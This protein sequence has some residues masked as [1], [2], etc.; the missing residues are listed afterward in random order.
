MFLPCY[1][2]M[3]KSN[4]ENI[5]EIFFD[6]Q[7]LLYLDNDSLDK[8]LGYSL[9]I[10]FFIDQNLEKISQFS[11][12]ENIKN[13]TLKIE[14]INQKFNNKHRIIILYRT[15]NLEPKLNSINAK[16]IININ[17]LDIDVSKEYILRVSDNKSNKI[18]SF[19][20]KNIE[21]LKTPLFV[22]FINWICVKTNNEDLEQIDSTS[23]IYQIFTRENLRNERKNWNTKD[24]FTWVKYQEDRD[25]LFDWDEEKFSM[26]YNEGKKYYFEKNP[27][28]VE[29]I[30][31][32]LAKELGTNF[33]DTKFREKINILIENEEY[34]W[35][36]EYRFIKNDLKFE[37]RINNSLNISSNFPLLKKISEFEIEFLHPSFSDYYYAKSIFYDLKKGNLI[38][39]EN[40]EFYEKQLNEF[41]WKELDIEASISEKKTYQSNLLKNHTFETLTHFINL[42]EREFNITSIEYETIDYFLS[43]NISKTALFYLAKAYETYFYS[44]LNYNTK[45]PNEI[46]DKGLNPLFIDYSVFLYNKSLETPLLENEEEKD[47]RSFNNLGNIYKNAGLYEDAE[48]FYKKGIK[49]NSDFEALHFNLGILYFEL[50]NYEEAILSFNESVRIIP[51]GIKNNWALSVCYANLGN[52]EQS[53]KYL[54]I[55]ISK[56]S[57]EDYKNYLETIHKILKEKIP[58]YEKIEATLI[59]SLKSST[60]SFI[61][62]TSSFIGKG[63]NYLNSFFVKNNTLENNKI[64][65]SENKNNGIRIIIGD[66]TSLDVDAIINPANTS[67]IGFGGLDGLIH[68]AAGSELTEECKKLNGCKTGE[69]KITSGYKLVAKNII[70]TVGPIW[71]GGDYNEAE[72]LANCYKNSL[73]LASENNIKTI[74]FPSISTGNNYFPLEKAVKIAINEIKEYQK[75]NTLPEEIIICC[76]DTETYNA[77]ISEMNSYFI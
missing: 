77:Y 25:R 45:N 49:I 18:T 46:N 55:L 72:L 34:L 44:N 24:L 2:K 66:I 69:S 11:F 61:N 16:N 60:S 37:K 19:L 31:M 23:A 6:T 76:F 59:E 65:V 38:D 9:P 56:I 15:N 74:A 50:K 30:L 36:H 54:K 20:D 14:M 68:R 58:N 67:L 21:I 3:N 42:F 26:V 57:K 28:P 40:K 12:E 73:K 33:I 64:I 32:I 51:N 5:D 48:I 17:D 52:V 62:N 4:Y 10:L 47:Y 41:N 63:V 7:N 75:N 70:H 29:I 35:L 22:D 43:L 13:I 1:L 8:F 71:H 39:I 53:I 27:H